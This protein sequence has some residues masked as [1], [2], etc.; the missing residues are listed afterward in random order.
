MPVKAIKVVTKVRL[1]RLAPYR[2]AARVRPR[3]HPN[4]AIPL[5]GSVNHRRGTEDQ[6]PADLPVARFGDPTKA[7]LPA[8]GILSRHQP[9]PGGE[10]PCTFEQ[11]DVGNSRCDQR[12]GDRADTRDRC[13]A[14]R[15]IILPCV[16]DNLRFKCADACDEREALFE[17]SREHLA[18][19]LRE[20]LICI[21]QHKKLVQ[22]ADTVR[23][24]QAKLARQAASGQRYVVF[25]RGS[26][27]LMEDA[28][29][30]VLVGAASWEFG[31]PAADI[32]GV[33]TVAPAAKR[34][35]PGSASA[36]TIGVSILAA[37]F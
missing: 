31:E 6:Q 10:V 16:S 28:A 23:N 15:G 13:Q 12:R 27:A 5:W 2:P 24:G 1:R 35:E 14:A 32:A 8:G 25:F 22:L 3:P 36:T 37:R 33:L 29:Q 17:Q 21:H 19:L 11:A 20:G 7:G 9:E 34:A 4:D 18:C 26:S 30:T